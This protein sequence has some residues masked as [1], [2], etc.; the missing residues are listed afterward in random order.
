MLIKAETNVAETKDVFKLILQEPERVFEM[1]QFNF[2]EIAERTLCEMLKAELTL[3]LG[4]EPYKRVDNPKKNHRNGYYGK[5]YTVKNIGELKLQ[6]PRDRVGNFSSRLIKKYDSYDKALE[7]DVCLM[8]LSGISTRGI[9]LI[10]KQILG[11]K[12]S[13]GE[14]SQINK[15]LMSGIDAW[16]TR[17]L[18]DEK[19][20]YMYIDGVNFHMRTG[21][22]V[23]I[24]PMLVV[25]G[26]KEDNRKIFLAIQRGDK[27]KASTWREV[28]K[29]LKK[30][31]L[32]KD[33][34][35]LGVMDGLQGLMTVFKEEFPQARIQRCQLHVTRNILCKVTKKAKTEVN[36][37]LRD[38]FYASSR[39]KAKESF[40]QFVNK[41]DNDFPSAVKCLS[42]VIDECLTFFS[43]PQ[44]QWKSIRTTNTIER[45]NKEF[46]RRT[47][48]ME[49]LAGEKSAYRLLSFIAL[50]M[51]LYWRSH[52]INKIM[53]LPLPNNFTQ[54]A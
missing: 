3:Y 15:E 16:R 18:S 11:R 41:Y 32:D 13:H 7:K 27:E 4:R 47:H 31:G 19:I 50:K 21:H 43:F 44:E 40:K 35:L 28:F 54:T 46:K 22:S 17:D 25:V 8:F 10:S 14:V 52:P 26:V 5:N 53:A 38:I 45:V 49:I 34:I 51:E 1:M 33:A 37:S 36:D 2:K 6:I 20:K 48:S 29:D 39:T 30:R 23:E 24:V 42:N 9:E 12:I